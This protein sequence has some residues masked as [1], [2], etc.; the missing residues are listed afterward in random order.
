MSNKDYLMIA[1]LLIG[2]GVAVLIQQRLVT[3]VMKRT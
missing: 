1:A 2:A 3:A